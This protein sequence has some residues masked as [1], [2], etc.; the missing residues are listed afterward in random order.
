MV[1]ALRRQAFTLVELLV[2][3]GI[4][5]I[6]IGILLPALSRAREASYVVKCASNL[7]TI[8]QGMHTYVSENKSTFPAAYIYANMTIVGT[9]QQPT[10][11]KDGY[12]HWSSF[13]F[14]KA[15]GNDPNVYRTLSGWEIFQCPTIQNGGL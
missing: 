8:G 6:L 3:I 12:I 5:A 13:I 7:R 2:V 15:R 9:N 11:A 10:F 14:K 4:I 1:R